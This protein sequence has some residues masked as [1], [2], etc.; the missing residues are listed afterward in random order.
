MRVF[1]FEG[2]FGSEWSSRPKLTLLPE[3]FLTTPELEERTTAVD[4]PSASDPSNATV[5]STVHPAAG[6][7]Q[8]LT[9]QVVLVA[10]LLD[11]QGATDDRPGNGKIVGPS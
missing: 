1:Q 6:Q 8:G 9:T 11:K 10:D 4:V 5:R 3:C 7:A 2:L